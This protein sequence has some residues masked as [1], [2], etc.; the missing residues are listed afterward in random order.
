MKTS[1]SILHH[2]CFLFNFR[3]FSEGLQAIDHFGNYIDELT[4]KLTVIRQVQDDEKTELMEV[5]NSL[6]NSPGLEKLVRY[7][8][9]TLYTYNGK[10]IELGFYEVAIRYNLRKL[11][12]HS[13]EIYHI[14]KC[15]R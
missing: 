11:F 10:T 2:H 7:N 8:V 6:K 15:T 12:I 14:Y 13:P 1:K 9:S 3:Y 4:G 5:R